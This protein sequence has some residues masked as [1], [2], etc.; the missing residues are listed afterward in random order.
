LRWLYE[1]RVFL[2]KHQEWEVRTVDEHL[3]AVGRM[4]ALLDNR[5]FEAIT[6]H[7]VLAF[8]NAL[9]D[10]RDDEGNGSIS[11][12]TVT[13]VLSRCEALFKWLSARPGIKLDPHLPGYFNLSRKER[14]AAASAVKGTNL[15]FD[16]AI[17][18]FAAMPDSNTIEL[19]NRAIIAMFICTGIRIAALTTLRGKHVNL[20]TR[21]I[22]QDPREVDTKFGK[23]I[24]T[25]LLNLGPALLNTMTAWA[26][27]RTQNGFGDNE[28]FFLPD[29]YIQPN[30]VGLGYRP[31]SREP[32]ICWKSIDPVQQI[33]KYAASAA[34]F[35][36]QNISSH[37]FRKAAHPF[38][39]KR[40]G[41][42]TAEEVALLLNFGHTPIETIRKHYAAMPE[43]QREELLDELCRRALSSR[44]EL[45]L[46]LEY[47][48]KTISEADPD[49]QRAKDIFQR[50][51]RFGEKP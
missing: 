3:R 29:R 21:W 39:A 13:H 33:V 25:Y 35:A 9:R 31:S 42:Q 19:R 20:N 18:I 7:D 11:R 8:K 34:G 47:E 17:S 12:S 36:E 45:E 40:G 30:G 1:Y 4:S 46:Y 28:P 24:R 51:S 50:N 37:D 27:W 15:T 14:G 22:N 6:I 2:D 48:R 44:S 32:A 16:Q 49:F 10:L 5:P 41:M 38:L 23:H 26:N 43:D